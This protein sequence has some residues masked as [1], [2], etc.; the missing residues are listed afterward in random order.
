M[1]RQQQQF[2]EHLIQRI[3][4]LEQQESSQ[5]T[6]IRDLTQDRDEL[7]ATVRLWSCA[8]SRL[9]VLETL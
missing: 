6:E 5:R 7:V 4:Y 2:L 8:H 1:D 9:G 3:T